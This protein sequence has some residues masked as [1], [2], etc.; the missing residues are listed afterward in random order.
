[1]GKEFSF[2]FESFNITITIPS[3][4]LVKRHGYQDELA[5]IISSQK[6]DGIQIPLKYEVYKVYVNVEVQEL[7]DIPEEAFNITNIGSL[8]EADQRDILDNISYKYE[9]IARRAFTY[10]LEILRWSANSPLIGVCSSTRTKIEQSRDLIDPNTSK[11]L[12]SST[13]RISIKSSKAVT[14]EELNLTLNRVQKQ[15]ELPMHIKFL[16]DAKESI[17]FGNIHRATV[18]LAL[19]SE[20]F[21]R[22]S[23]FDLIPKDLNSDFVTFIEEANINQYLNR[24]FKNAIP[25]KDAKNFKS[26]KQEISSLFSRRNNYMHMGKMK[27]LTPERYEKYLNAVEDLLQIKLE[28]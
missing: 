1:M 3:E 13:G 23:V 11:R 19:C 25:S 10:W 14:T 4:E 9:L 2:E 28:I 7:Q 27:D 12:Y 20:N 21:L 17:Q 15:D 26:I 5:Y 8:Y 18:E 16:H 24:F 22:Y 6:V